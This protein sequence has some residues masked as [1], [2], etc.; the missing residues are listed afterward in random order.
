[1]EGVSSPRNMGG[2]VRSPRNMEGVGA[3]GTWRG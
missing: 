1:M 2:G 3:L